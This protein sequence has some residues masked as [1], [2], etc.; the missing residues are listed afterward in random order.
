MKIKII[1]ILIILI[2]ILGWQSHPRNE[3]LE[4]L[5]VGIDVY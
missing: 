5:S 1:L 2:L 4:D 3:D